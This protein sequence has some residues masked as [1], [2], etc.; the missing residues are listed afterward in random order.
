MSLEDFQPQFDVWNLCAVGYI[1]GRNP[2]FKALYGICSSVWKCEVTLT[3]H[4]SGWL[5]YRFSREEDKNS[6]FN[7]GPYM[8][9]RRPLILKSMP[10]FVY[11]SNE[12]MSR[13]PVWIH[14]P[15]LPLCCWSSSCLSKIASVLGKP[16]QS[17]HVTSMLSRMSY[18][19]VLVEIDLREVL[20][21]SVAVSL[22]SGPLLQQKVVY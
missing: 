9:S 16:I 10:H 22:L 21:H 1:S 11:F 3:F 17:D 12:G 6:V 14:F 7:G 20:Q 15:N 4:D 5:I 19:R 13:V 2:G 8:V 18:A